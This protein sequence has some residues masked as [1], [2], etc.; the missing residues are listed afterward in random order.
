MAKQLW[1]PPGEPTELLVDASGDLLHCEDCPCDT[2]DCEE[3]DFYISAIKATDTPC[4]WTFTAEHTNPLP[5]NWTIIGYTWDFTNP[6]ST[7]SGK[8]AIKTF[9][10]DTGG[11]ATVTITLRHDTTLEEVDCEASTTV[12]CGC[13]PGDL[14][15]LADFT[16]EQ[17]GQCSIAFT[18]TTTERDNPIVGWEWDFDDG[19]TSTEENPSHQF[20]DGSGCPGDQ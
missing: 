1:H 16:W 3:I 5:D 11:S 17:T 6:N 19:N 2:V 9:D 7:A 10:D 20:N 13:P 12:R 18:N 8:T 14:P 15:P 4:V